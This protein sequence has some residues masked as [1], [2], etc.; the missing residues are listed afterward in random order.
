MDSVPDAT[1]ERA[2]LLFFLLQW[3]EEEEPFTPFRLNVKTK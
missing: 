3:S 1:H 2:R